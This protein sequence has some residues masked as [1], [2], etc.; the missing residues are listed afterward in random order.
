M[1]LSSSSEPRID[2]EYTFAQVGIEQAVVDWGS[3]CGKS[4]TAMA[5]SL[6]GQLQSAA[7]ICL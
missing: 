4:F 3:S 5:P 2:V 1:I 6:N 7:D